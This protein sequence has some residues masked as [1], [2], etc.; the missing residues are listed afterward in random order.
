MFVESIQQV[1][2]DIT[3]QS[4]AQLREFLV[5]AHS[6]HQ[7]DSQVLSI[8]FQT[9]KQEILDEGYEWGELISMLVDLVSAD[10]QEDQHGRF[11]A[12]LDRLYASNASLLEVGSVMASDYSSA[13]EE[14]QL[15]IQDA[16]NEHAEL[17]GM[18]GGTSKFAQTWHKNPNRTKQQKRKVRA[19]DAT[20][21]LAAGSF[22]GGVSYLSYKGY[23]A[24]KA[25]KAEK[26]AQ[27][28]GQEFETYKGEV[29]A[30]A[31][32]LDYK[33]MHNRPAYDNWDDL[34]DYKEEFATHNMRFD[35]K[36]AAKDLPFEF[37]G[38][39]E[40]SLKRERAENLIRNPGDGY[41]KDLL[42][43]LDI[44]H[45]GEDR[46]WERNVEKLKDNP[47]FG[48]YL[49]TEKGFDLYNE[50]QSSGKSLEDFAQSKNLTKH[51]RKDHVKPNDEEAKVA[52]R[53]DGGGELL[54]TNPAVAETELNE[55]T[56]ARLEPDKPTNPDDLDKE[57]LVS[58]VMNDKTP[59]VND[60]INYRRAG[61]EARRAVNNDG[62]R[63]Q[64]PDDKKGGHND[65]DRL[66]NNGE[67]DRA[68]EAPD[69]IE[70]EIGTAVDREVKDGVLSESKVV[71]NDVETGFEDAEEKETSAMEDLF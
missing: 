71:M 11:V 62:M 15:L 7:S 17:A 20:E 9:L 1:H 70:E 25:N 48:K 47:E 55:V 26:E 58:A 14:L 30:S 23:K 32:K 66:D 13:L 69:R 27:R 60:D 43:R 41:E 68:L 57:D 36:S 22:I 16:Q 4:A 3:E 63:I 5:T 65:G 31:D 21:I 56:S 44:K 40:L 10:M 28:L 64:L 37:K 18:A 51:L 54:P 38:R 12:E 8:G 6:R 2:P 39:T 46:D 59:L 42:Q 49:E 19:I 45:N 67:I 61:R 52:E 33:H 29:K 34:Q 35:F 24:Y 53:L 50:F